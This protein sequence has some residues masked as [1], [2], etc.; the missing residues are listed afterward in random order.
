MHDI[1]VY[2]P[3]CGDAVCPSRRRRRYGHDY[4]VADR[5]PREQRAGGLERRVLG[6]LRPVHVGPFDRFEVLS[7]VQDGS[8]PRRDVFAGA[9]GD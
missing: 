2:I 6:V 5:R 7:A 4:R 8:H 3:M 1:R 9:C